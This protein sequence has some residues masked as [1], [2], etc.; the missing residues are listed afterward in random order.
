MTG[1]QTCALPIYTDAD[2]RFRIE[3]PPDFHGDVGAHD[4]RD[5]LRQAKSAGVAAGQGEVILQLAAPNARLPGEA[6]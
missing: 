5:W 6:R 4:V 2:G 1:V 3:V